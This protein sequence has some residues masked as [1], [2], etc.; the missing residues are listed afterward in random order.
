MKATN[1]QQAYHDAIMDTPFG[2]PPNPKSASDAM[3]TPG[4]HLKS[5]EMDG[6][7]PRYYGRLV[8]VKDGV[9]TVASKG[10]QHGPEG[11][12]T[13]WTGTAVEYIRMWNCD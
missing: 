5:R 8:S 12:P 4:C 13:V 1:D 2:A 6:K 7:W 11:K 3:E 9:Y 10:P